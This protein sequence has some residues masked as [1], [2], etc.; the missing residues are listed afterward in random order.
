MTGN[1]PR[2]MPTIV[3]ESVK[4]HVREL[5]GDTE[6]KRQRLGRFRPLTWRNTLRPVFFSELYCVYS[7]E[8]EGGPYPPYISR[9]VGL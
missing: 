9:G 1:L 5:D 3:D 4:V 2:G 6:R 8:N 7:D